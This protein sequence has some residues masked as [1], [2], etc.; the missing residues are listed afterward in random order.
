MAFRNPI[1]FRGTHWNADDRMMAN[2]RNDTPELARLQSRQGVN[3]TTVVATSLYPLRIRNP[4]AKP[5][6]NELFLY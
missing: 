2:E 5:G 3:E 4:A 6:T 1:L